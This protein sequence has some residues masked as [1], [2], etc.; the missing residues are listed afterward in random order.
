MAGP[1]VE[2]ASIDGGAIH[3]L[4]TFF[5]A[6]TNVQIAFTLRMNL[7]L[8]G[9][10]TFVPPS[11]TLTEHADQFY[12]TQCAAFVRH[13]TRTRWILGFVPCTLRP[14]PLYGGVPEILPLHNVRVYVRLHLNTEP[15]YQYW[16]LPP[17][18]TELVCLP[19]IMTFTYESPHPDGRLRSVLQQLERELI[20]EYLLQW[21]DTIAHRGRALPYMLSTDPDLKIQ[22]ERN[23]PLQGLAAPNA[24]AAVPGA[25]EPRVD[26]DAPSSHLTEPT[27]AR[28]HGHDITGQL[29]LQAP[30]LGEQF[31][32][33]LHTLMRT[34]YFSGYEHLPQHRIPHPVPL[35]E[36]LGEY[37]LKT[38]LARRESV[39]MMLGIP[40]SMLTTETTTD[41]TH[42]DMMQRTQYHHEYFEHA[43][44][45]LQ[46]EV[47]LALEQ[48]LTRLHAPALLTAYARITEKPTVDGALT[49][50]QWKIH[51]NAF[52]HIQIIHDLY[53]LGVL[54]YKAYIAHLSARYHLPLESFSKTPAIT[55]AELAGI[56][57][58]PAENAS[59]SKSA[60]NK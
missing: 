49:A 16:T 59:S 5:D 7:L 23:V 57:E 29:A 52:P 46:R 58:E 42:K 28:R 27:N 43:Q 20:H 22:S 56:V 12:N 36:G 19:N 39:L 44:L 45:T 54:E 55:P 24:R 13:Y 10:I 11:G 40:M 8:T 26:A 48:L 2:F 35:P 37:L 41:N 21:L 38:R 34:P 6:D 47:T 15:E 50:I 9:K 25:I 60:K 1:P 30:I 14:H 18:A 32:Y 33:H 4:S 53:R 51:I 17:G 31:E 3:R